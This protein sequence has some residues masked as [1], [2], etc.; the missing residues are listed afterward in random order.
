MGQNVCFWPRCTKLGPGNVSRCTQINPLI[1]VGVSL[2]VGPCLNG[3]R[4]S[5]DWCQVHSIL[6]IFRSCLVRWKNDR[7]Q[8]REQVQVGIPSKGMRVSQACCSPGLLRTFAP[9]HSASHVQRGS[10]MWHLCLLHPCLPLLMRLCYQSWFE[11]VLNRSEDL[12][13]TCMQTALFPGLHTSFCHIQALCREQSLL[14]WFVKHWLVSKFVTSSLDAWSCCN[15]GLLATGCEHK[16]LIKSGN[17]L[18]FPH[19]IRQS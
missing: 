15:T 6:R 9:K 16:Y 2:P 17:W 10:C 19:I 3:L 18:Q 13:C 11:N 12:L 8:S 4:C 5:I 7:T 1:L 14:E